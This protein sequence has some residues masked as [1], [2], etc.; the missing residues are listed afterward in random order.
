[1]KK[2]T[3]K[4]EGMHCASCVAT[5]E[6]VLSKT[7]GV[8]SAS[9]NFASESALIEFDEKKISPAKL[10]EVVGSA[11]YH[12]DIGQAERETEEKMSAEDHSHHTASLH[13]S[14]VRL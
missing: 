2:D 9:V 14:A 13:E 3:Y 6:R 1:M 8:H 10:A 12:L 7:A 4:V 5:I 11:G